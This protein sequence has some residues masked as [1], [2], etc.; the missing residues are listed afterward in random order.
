MVSDSRMPSDTPRVPFDLERTIFEMSGFSSPRQIPNLMLVAHRVK[1]WVEPLLYR[2][3]FLSDGEAK[4][5]CIP[6]FTYSIFLRLLAAKPADFFQK[7]VSHLF[8]GYTDSPKTY[9]ED[10]RLILQTCTNVTDFFDFLGTPLD[11]VQSL[12]CVRRIALKCEYTFSVPSS[13]NF[14]HPLCRTITHLELLGYKVSDSDL[15]GI[16]HIPLLS[17]VSFNALEMCAYLF[18]SVFPACPRLGCIVLLQSA[19]KMDSTLEPFLDDK[20]FVVVHQSNFTLDWQRGAAG[21]VSYWDVADAFV[22]ARHAGRIGAITSSI[23]DE[24]V[25]WF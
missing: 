21:G 10:A 5:D 17:H 1:A 20:R 25:S 16:R 13:T 6:T 7:A 22:R 8:L 4:M 14:S 11:Q 12:K 2:V 9:Y 24:D 3:V 19:A 23:S 15:A 18:A